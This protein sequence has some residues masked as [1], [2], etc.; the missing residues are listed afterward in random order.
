MKLLKFSLLLFS[1][2]IFN[3]VSAQD[4]T[5]VKISLF[6]YSPEYSK[7]RARLVMYGTAGGYVISMS[8]L[9]T[10]WYRN[11]ASS[12]FHLFNDNH[13]WLQV[14]KA[15]HAVTSYFVGKTF[16]NLM[17]WSGFSENKATWYGGSVGFLYLTGVEMFD[18][19]SRDWG[20]S[21]GDMIANTTGAALFIGQQ[22]FWNEQRIILKYSFHKT[23]FADYRPD[24]LGEGLNEQMLKDYNGQTYWMSANISSFIKSE[25]NFPKWL[26]FAAGYGAEGMTGGFANIRGDVP[27]FERYRQYYLSFDVDLSRIPIKKG[28]AKSLLST[29]N[30]IKI[31]FPAV[32]FNSKGIVKFYPFYF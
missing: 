20:F 11:S 15:G 16:F 12:S 24:V 27:E 18:G 30:F 1:L 17:K 8:G 31:P 4:T 29:I 26:N 32:E 23:E 5:A 22:Y 13:E 21:T 28:F 2:F 6:E 19:F 3:V 7:S 10:L 25:N 14:D 9:Y